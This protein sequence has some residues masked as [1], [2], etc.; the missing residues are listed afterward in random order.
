[1][2][3]EKAT[4]NNLSEILEIISEAQDYFRSQGIEQ[5]QNGY[6]NAAVIQDDIR[7]S[8]GYVLREENHIVAYASLSLRKEAAYE[9]ILNGTWRGEPYAVIHRLA[10]G[11]RYKGQGAAAFLLEQAE[12]ICREKNLHWIRVDTHRDNHS[13][14]KFL[15]KNGFSFCGTIYLSDGAPRIA[16]DRY[17]SSKS[18]SF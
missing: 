17:V 14:Q 18:T 4:E 8:F 7:Q 2:E 15:L 10:V 6:P 5:W 9:H 3:L 1:M 13:M 12:E 11:N 16:F